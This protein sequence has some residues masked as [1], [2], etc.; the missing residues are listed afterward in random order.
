[1]LNRGGFCTP[2]II[3][4]LFFRQIWINHIYTPINKISFKIIITTVDLINY[5]IIKSGPPMN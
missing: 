2:H 5:L 4:L 3:N 1:M